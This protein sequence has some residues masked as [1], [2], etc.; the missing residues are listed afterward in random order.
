MLRAETPTI[1]AA[2]IAER[3]DVSRTTLYVYF[4]RTAITC[5]GV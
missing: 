2:E 1:S 4:P 3:L 5:E